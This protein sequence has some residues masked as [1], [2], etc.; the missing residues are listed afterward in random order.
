MGTMNK[1]ERSIVPRDRIVQHRDGTDHFDTELILAQ[2]LLDG[3]CVMDDGLFDND[4]TIC[5]LVSCNDLFMWGCGDYEPVRYSQLPELY[6]IHMADRVW[7]S[8]KWCIL[9]RKF[10][11]QPPVLEAMKR[12]GVWDLDESLL[13]ANNAE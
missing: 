1:E 10:F 12:A 13:K 8:D 6:E 2:L 9:Q 4:S 11:P 7:S 3:T 5:A